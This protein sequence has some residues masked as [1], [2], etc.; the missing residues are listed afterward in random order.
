MPYKDREVQLEAQRQHYRDN[1]E[2]YYKR[3]QAWKLKSR[4]IAKKEKLKGCEVCGYKKCA[5]SI[6]YHHTDPSVKEYAMGGS[7]INDRYKEE[8]KKCIL[9]C[10]NCHVE[11]H[12]GLVEDHPWEDVLPPTND[13]R[14][15]A[16]RAWLT[17]DKKNGCSLCGYST[18]EKAIH[19]HHIDPTTKE[20]TISQ[21]RKRHFSVERALPEIEKCIRVCANCHGEIHEGLID[22]K[23]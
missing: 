3:G 11:I 20:Y 8:I 19:Y 9:V 10:H 18:C 16:L 6:V 4:E 22:L 7:I 2:A 23:T 15:K 13:I 14:G 5:T 21:M 12:E 17:E 1:K